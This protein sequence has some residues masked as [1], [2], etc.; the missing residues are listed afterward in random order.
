MLQQELYSVH[1]GQTLFDVSTALYGDS[2][3]AMQLAYE[4]NLSL[5]DN[6]FSG[7]KIKPIESKQNFQVLQVYKQNATIPATGVAK[8]FIKIILPGGIGHMQI[9]NN[10][11]VS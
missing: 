1:D 9:G 10:F 7:Q 11:K 5:T 8:E 4:N 2:S 6:L 3:Q